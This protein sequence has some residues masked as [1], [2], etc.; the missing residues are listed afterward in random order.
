[1]SDLTYV[2]RQ[3]IYAADD[4]VFAYELLYRNSKENW[5]DIDD[6]NHAT[7]ELLSNVFTS[8]GLDT[9]VGDRRA[10]IN[11]PR[12]FL[13]GE[14]PLPEIKQQ[15]VIEILE[16][17]KPDADVLDALRNLKQ[18]G[19]TLALD[20]YVFEEHLEP[21]LEL[22]DIIKIDIMAS[23][24]D[25]LA[26]RVSELARYKVELLAEK[27]ETE[28]EVRICR[29]L[30]F[31]YFQGYHF[32]KP[33]VVSGK[34]ITGNQLATMQLLSE[35]NRADV[36]I[37]EL[38]DLI[39]Q[40][41]AISYKLLRYVNSAMY[42]FNREIDS[43]RDAIVV[44][45]VNTLVKLVNMVA[46]GSMGAVNGDDY[47]SA[48]FRARMCER[49]A[50]ATGKKDEGASYFLVGLFSSLDRLLGVPME[51]VLVMLPLADDIKLAISDHSGRYGEILAAVIAYELDDFDNLADNSLD[52]QQVIDCYV[53]A[54]AWADES[55]ALVA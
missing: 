41:I 21:F 42:S 51:E 55:S 39:Q 45:G 12:E 15:V 8:I 20:D 30:G 54:I 6:D 19:Y 26:D 24:V 5:A 46:I 9:L 29:E 35:L 3:P 36:T 43:I 11:M 37:D 49:L 17:V 48:M 27:V 32:A 23:G 50:I 1:M 34:K 7:A 14:Y 53:E 31:A 52:P 10:F 2:G 16:H 25:T 22:A 44:L 13:L 33:K 38:T 18:Q 40:D 4:T 47:R 28:D